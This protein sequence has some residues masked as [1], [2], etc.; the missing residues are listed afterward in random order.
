MNKTK[1]QTMNGKDRLHQLQT[2]LAT[3]ENSISKLEEQAIT[4]EQEAVQL[5][6]GRTVKPVDPVKL[7][8]LHHK[9]SVLTEAIKLQ[10]QAVAAQHRTEQKQLKKQLMVRHRELAQQAHRHLMA[11]VET[12]MEDATFCSDAAKQGVALHHLRFPFSLSPTM[13]FNPEKMLQLWE[14][15]HGALLADGGK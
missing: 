2:D 12:A 1:P 15:S 9:R 14:Q 11:F 4:P 6:E 13:D 10:K 5:L 7:N 3:V 8:E